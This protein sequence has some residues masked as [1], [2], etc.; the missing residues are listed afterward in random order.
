MDD[1]TNVGVIDTHSKRVGVTPHRKEDGPV[2]MVALA[3]AHQIK[4]IAHV[5]SESE[6]DVALLVDEV[7]MLLYGRLRGDGRAVRL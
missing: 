3:N 7:D 2:I 4:K 5:V 1:Q 6:A